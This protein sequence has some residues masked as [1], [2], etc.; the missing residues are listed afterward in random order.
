MNSLHIWLFVSIFFTIILWKIAMPK[1]NDTRITIGKF[2]VPM[3]FA[4][5]FLLRVFL[6]SRF[7][8][9]GTDIGCF[10]SWADRM[11]QIGPS[12][13]YSKDYFS[14][15]PPLYLYVLYVI[16]FLKESFSLLPLSPTHLFLLKAPAIFADLGIG[17]L[18]YRSCN[19]LVGIRSS[20][21]L[22]SIY[23]L[24][25][26]VILNSCLW[27]QIDSVFT[28]FLLLVCLFL[29]KQN[30][31]PAMLLFGFGILLKP[32]MLIFTPILIVG[33]IQYVYRGSFS[34]RML[35]KASS[36]AL[37]TIVLMILTAA[38]FGME[39]VISQYVDTVTSYPY[40]SVNAY[41]FWAGMGLNW[42]SQ[43]TIFM[44]MTAK[45]WGT[46]FIV[47]A[48]GISILL[49]LK[50]GNLHQKH[51]VIGAFL[52][53]TVFTYSVRMHDRYLYPALP[54]LLLSFAGF[55]S[56]QLCRVPSKSDKT[57][58]SELL[59]PTLK[60]LFPLMFTMLTTL[61]FY[62][63]GHVLFF[64][65]PH[66]YDPDALPLKL[67]GIA[68]VLCSLF[69]Y[70]ILARLQ[71]KKE[72]DLAFYNDSIKVS[73]APVKIKKEHMRISR[74]DV[75]L[76]LFTI[77]LYSV[78]AL[79][80]LGSLIAPQTS[81]SLEKAKPVNLSFSEEHMP[82]AMAY[83]L[84]PEHNRSILLSILPKGAVQAQSYSFTLENVFTWT[85]IDL[86]T[87]GTKISITAQG[88]HT[89]AMEF[90]FLDS[91]GEPIRPI[92][93]SEYSELFDEMDTY[94]ET[95]SFRNSMYFDEIY[96][97]RTAYEYL[98]GLR[99]Y[100]NTHPPLGKIFIS[101]GILLFG[102]NPFGWR[103]IGTLF[104]IAMIPILY[105]FAKRLT[106]ETASAAIISWIFA[107]DFMHFAQTRIA[108][109]DVYI[110]FFII[111]MYYFLFYFFT[112]DFGTVK[113]GY[114]CLPLGLCGISMGLGIACKWTGVYAGA[115]MGLLFFG[116]LI[117][118]YTR[119]KQYS[120]SL[121]LSQSKN[122]LTKN[123]TPDSFKSKSLFFK[124][125]KKL[126][127]FCLVFFVLVPMAIY[128]I[129][130]LP[131]RDN[132]GHSMIK[133]AFDNQ[134]TMYSYHS[135]LEATHYFASPF[136][137]W[138]FIVRPIWYYSKVL[139]PTLREGIS[140]F[141]NPFVW[142]M[143][144]PALVY[145]IYLAIRKKDGRAVF[146]IVGFSAQYLP[147]FF[148][149][150]M[151]FIYHYFPSVVF[152]VLMIGYAFRNLRELLPRKGYYALVLFY[153]ISVFALF[154]LFYPVLAGQPVEIDFANHFLRWFKT[155]VLVAQ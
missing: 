95:F 3:L 11:A 106:G 110:V 139:S 147:W 57:G 124:K 149:E 60:T 122:K 84:A 74:L 150:R 38:P 64:Y 94:P 112:L 72:F 4:F 34:M 29:E 46:I 23:L 127:V 92:N 103:I 77:L 30:L 21:C 17:Y 129:S 128:L 142:W 19:K 15:Y 81:F 62:N 68:M 154:L 41:N 13:F 32:Q 70:Y 125:T 6:T 36:Y 136:Y 105:L 102:M 18:I 61:H 26:V 134:N 27:G 143:G 25:P 56:R 73:H 80:D 117:I 98:H 153:G 152:L 88:D 10:S 47:L 22:T 2:T 33:T 65:D 5:A 78:F 148:V 132:T 115:G 89:Q 85:K 58:I 104:G 97:A 79:R 121:P 24:Q 96:H 1:S 116:Y 155:W 87:P 119:L 16:G 28:F 31:L 108:T 135:K 9:F 118:M 51:A 45:A 82:S 138:P 44:G 90:V 66:H 151:T 126:I 114:L 14:D 145:M 12:G 8:G 99:S 67:C 20:I 35:M 52:I 69:S 54:L 55:C 49:G 111:C 76:L 140:S 48:A 93:A 133:Q 63:C 146:L 40:A 123:D 59:S 137:E 113:F 75:L 50:L 53:I 37:L 91:D 71:S 109:I 86:P 101:L 107:F 130:Y 131:F 7:V 120:S 39:N 100:E 141:G 144:I 43:T 83:Y 42:A